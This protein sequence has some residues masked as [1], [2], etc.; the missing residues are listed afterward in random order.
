[1]P[2]MNGTL[3][4]QIYDNV[5]SKILL[6]LSVKYPKNIV[7]IVRLL[8]KKRVFGNDIWFKN[9][10]LNEN[11]HSAFDSNMSSYSMLIFYACFKSM[12]RKIMWPIKA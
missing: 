8:F 6:N 5:Y 10:Y 4:H 2:F 3:F 11:R 12:H 9:W 1:M 7:Q